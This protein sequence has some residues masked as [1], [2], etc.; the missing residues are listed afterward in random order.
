MASSLGASRVTRQKAVEFF[1]LRVAAIN[2]DIELC[3]VM[4]VTCRSDFDATA[5]INLVQAK[6]VAL[7]EEMQNSIRRLR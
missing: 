7:A 4:Q 3:E 6:Y 2:D 1:K 5:A